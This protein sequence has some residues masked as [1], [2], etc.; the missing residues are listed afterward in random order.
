[1]LLGELITARVYDLPVK[2]VVFNNATLGMVKLEML[3]EGLP[4]YGTD[5]PEV[6]YAAIGT[7]V[8]I[9]SVRVTKPKDLAGA[10]SKAFAADGPALVEVMT[11]PN[12]LSI[13]P[14]ITSGQVRGFATAMT[15]QVL[16]GGMGE[17]MSMARS[18]LR[19]LPR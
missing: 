13:P 4:S 14:S 12:A 15:K 2:V 6:D 9:P 8:G 18:N 19:N 5:S 16:G 3:V 17:V 10:F 7:A 11:D 1:M